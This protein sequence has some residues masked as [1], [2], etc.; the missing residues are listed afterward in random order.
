MIVTRLLQISVLGAMFLGTSARCNRC[1]GWE[2]KASHE[3]KSSATRTTNL[4]RYACEKCLSVLS[5]EQRNCYEEIKRP[6][7]APE[8]TDFSN[9]TLLEYLFPNA[10]DQLVYNAEDQPLDENKPSGPPASEDWEEET[11]K[12]VVLNA[13]NHSAFVENQKYT[14][15]LYYYPKYPHYEMIFPQWEKIARDPFLVA[16]GLK[17]AK[18]DLQNNATVETGRFPTSSGELA[19]KVYSRGYPAHHRITYKAR[20]PN[21]V[22]ESVMLLGYLKKDIA[23][24]GI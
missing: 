2:R 23:R 11:G 10:N 5:P 6:A 4:P 24:R 18:F 19:I 22:N 21:P 7:P 13:G 3:I 20:A 15:V 14:M 8:Q 17:I 16:K 1:S 12:V 9:H